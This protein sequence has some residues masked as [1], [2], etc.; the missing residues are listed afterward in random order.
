MS[1][2]YIPNDPLATGVLP[3]RKV[4]P[5][6]DRP[7]NRGGLT[8]ATGVAEDTYDVGTSGFLF[9]QSREAALA[10]LEA[11]EAMSGST[12][13]TWQGNRKSLRLIAD[14]GVDLNAFYNR[15]SLSF[16]H[17]EGGAKVYFSGASTDVVAHETGHGILDSLRPEFW[18]S[19]LF[20]VNS[21]HEAFGDCMA[22]LTAFND[23]DSRAAILA[24]LEDK[25]AVES[26]A[27]ELA[28]GIKVVISPKHNAAV[29]R[30]ARNKF[31]HAIP[32]TLP[33][34]GSADDGPGK[35]IN[36]IHS[37]CQIF[38]GCFYDTV[39]NIFK[40]NG[41]ATE[42]G[43]L[44]AARIAGRLLIHAAQQ[45]PQKLR[46]FREVGR[47]MVLA[48]QQL[49]SGVNETAIREAFQGHGIP[50]SLGVALTAESALAGAAPTLGAA[51]SL[52][53][54]AKK[55]LLRRLSA[56]PGSKAVFRAIEIGKVK[57]GEFVHHRAVELGNLDKR[58]KNVVAMA[59]ETVLVGDSGGRAAVLG[60]MPHSEGTVDEVE[61]YVRSL[62]RKGAI[63][64]G[65]KPKPKAKG[66]VATDAQLPVAPVTH[67][68]KTVRGKKV[69]VRTRFACGCVGR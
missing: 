50:I 59:P 34:F 31:K 27:E 10:A 49:N 33:D 9:W 61:A 55:D 24:S 17:A 22:L 15:Q 39:V 4:S 57:V 8:L 41:P 36:E 7:A 18:D 21:F 52:A 38:S 47:A 11:F 67:A 20:E 28:D 66:I 54:A 32:S 60:M 65:D 42:A 48:D 46:F 16:F 2:N 64:F 37:F 3:M 5:R 43:L 29:P 26:T 53:A 63:D 23:K 69:L 1:I 40:A 13:K 56:A 12:F 35:L 44:A 62:L 25:N 51:A 58:L 30:R 19:S 68:V 14:A 6:S 45:A